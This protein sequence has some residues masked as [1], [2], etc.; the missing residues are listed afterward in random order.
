MV[1]FI[2]SKTEHST[3]DNIQTIQVSVTDEIERI[4]DKWGNKPVRP[5]KF[6]FD[7]LHPNDLSDL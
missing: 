4:I 1:F 3:K 6:I 2:G 7:I 5:K